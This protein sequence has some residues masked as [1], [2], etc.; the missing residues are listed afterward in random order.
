MIADPNVKVYVEAGLDDQERVETLNVYIR[1]AAGELTSCD[2]DYI[3]IRTASGNKFS[4]DLP[5]KVK[6]CNV[7]GLKQEDLE[8]GNADNKGYTG[9]GC[10]YRCRRYQQH[11]GLKNEIESRLSTWIG[12]DSIK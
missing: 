4:L 8:D 11:Y 6:T 10:P 1:E 7:K 2:S 12:I 3:R 5:G 9:K